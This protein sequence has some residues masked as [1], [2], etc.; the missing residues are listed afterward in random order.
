MLEQ[1]DD[2][3][4]TNSASEEDNEP[5]DSWLEVGSCDDSELPSFDKFEA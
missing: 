5:L 3:I 1:A 2:E 4:E